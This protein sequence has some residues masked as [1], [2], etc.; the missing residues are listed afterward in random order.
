M[1]ILFGAARPTRGPA[2]RAIMWPMASESPGQRQPDLEVL[3]PFG[4]G[5]LL[6]ADSAT[7]EIPEMEEGVPF[8][9]TA[10]AV[11]VPVRH[12]Q[13][14]D[15]DGLALTADE[16]IP[17]FAV[18]VRAFVGHEADCPVRF[19]G[20]IEV[21]SGRVSVGDADRDDTLELE[22]GLWRLQVALSPPDYP[23][24]VDVWLTRAFGT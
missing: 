8:P 1:P 10:T 12:T 16:A 22:P 19:D 7:S 9:S 3:R 17:E 21:P 2:G 6:V 13:D 24:R 14:V 20:R 15:I 5:I 4:W 23:D 11:A 18:K